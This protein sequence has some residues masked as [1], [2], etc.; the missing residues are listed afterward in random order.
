MCN[1]D[2]LLRQRQ[3][4]QLLTHLPQH[5]NCNLE[6]NQIMMDLLS[7]L[8]PNWLLH[9]YRDD[10]GPWCVDVFESVGERV[11]GE[12]ECRPL[13]YIHGEPI[14]LKDFLVK[15]QWGRGATCPSCFCWETYEGH[16][17]SLLVAGPS[18]V[19]HRASL[20]YGPI[21]KIHVDSVLWTGERI[22]IRLFRSLQFH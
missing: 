20:I 18:D 16:C 17:N 4:D 11:P 2:A 5:I 6:D 3:S 7:A 9:P 13:Q 22:K 14:Q 1:V 19:L 12:R 8:G 21:V 10:S 15:A